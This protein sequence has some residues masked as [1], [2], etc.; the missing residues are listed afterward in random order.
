MD[1]PLVL[2]DHD[3]SGISHLPNVYCHTVARMLYMPLVSRGR[4]SLIGPRKL[5]AFPGGR[6]TA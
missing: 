4:L 5:K 2:F 1:K 6:L 3:F